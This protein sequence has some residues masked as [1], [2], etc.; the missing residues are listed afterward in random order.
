MNVVLNLDIKLWQ[1]GQP[2]RR[3]S[4][5]QLREQHRALKMDAQLIKAMMI[6]NL[7]MVLT[8]DG[9]EISRCTCMYN[10]ESS[11]D[12][13]Q[14]YENHLPDLLE[15]KPVTI[16]FYEEM[17][18]WRLTPVGEEKMSW[19][20]LDT[21]K[22]QAKATVEQ[23]GECLRMPFI[24]SAIAWLSEAISILELYQTEAKRSGGQDLTDQI[25]IGR[26]LYDYSYK[27]LTE[28]GWQAS[29]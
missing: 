27:T 3:F 10:G 24:A 6:D 25:D 18:S 11:A 19:E 29:N 21:S 14:L 5:Q 9:K 7:G 4:A 16:H 2:E 20:I 15:K 26:R 28:M 12:L 23:Q 1:P 17:T 8:I 13:L 22:G